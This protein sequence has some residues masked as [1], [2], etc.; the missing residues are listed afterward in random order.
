MT[1]YSLNDIAR[2]AEGE[3]P[4][5]EIQAFEQALSGD[6]TLQEQLAFYR[7]VHSSLQQHFHK[8]EQ[9]QELEATL[10]QMRGEFFRKGKAP[11]KVVAMNRYLRYAMAAAM[12]VI[13]LFIWKPWQGDLYEQ[14]G[15]IQMLNPTERGNNND[16]LLQQAAIAF[17]Q[18]EYTTAA[19]YL[20]TVRSQQPDDSFTEFYYGVALMHSGK[21]AE[22]RQVLEALYN[23]ESVFKY[24]AAFQMA[25]SYLKE[26]NKTATREW[27]QKIPVDAANYGKAQE[28]LKKL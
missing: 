24:E 3:M 26:E 28:L 6:A 19:T 25:L 14:Y 4:A 10:Q 11:A 12:L 5:E 2:Y 18:K 21:T 17:N 22:A 27:L 8:D 23:G 7:E 20:Y 1:P 13:A 9:Q 16:S 15:E